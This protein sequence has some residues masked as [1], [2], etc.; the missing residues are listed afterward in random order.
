ME[1]K[2]GSEIIIRSESMGEMLSSPPSWIVRSGNALFLFIFLILLCLSWFIEYPDEITGDVLVT[3]TKAP[4]EL[5]NQT[6]IQLKSIDVIENEKVETGDLIAQFDIQANTED[7]KEIGV[8][9]K[10]L[11]EFRGDY[12]ILPR[13][14][15]SVRLGT[16]QESWT[17][18]NAQI[19]NWNTELEAD[20]SE[21]QIASIQREIYLREQLQ[22]IN[23]KRINISSDEYEMIKKELESSERLADQNAIS[24]QTLA[25]DKRSHSQAMQTIQS[26][27]EQKVQN[28]IALNSL[29]SDLIQLKNDTRLARQQKATDILLGITSLQT[30]LVNWEKSA[31]WIAPCKGKVVFNKILQVNR[32]YKANE[33]SV[34]IVPNGSGYNAIATIKVN[35]AGKVKSGQKVFIEL[36]DYPKTEFGML[37]GIVKS[38]TQIDKG[39]KYEVQIKLS[40]QL[41][42]TYNKQIPFKAQFKGK[43]KI[44]T[45]NKRL[46]A[47]FFEQLTNLIK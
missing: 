17:K 21:K 8:Y 28:L 33:A 26:Q 42:T 12:G 47:R 6:Y 38:K 41:K 4:I 14:T 34:V 37:E 25:T 45:K 18:L 31:V 44:I 32:F 10:H 19:L 15:G 5:S 36:T 9:L 3:T 27:K 29:K 13:Y 24:K 35:G 39:G 1:D 2:K 30:A 7:I 22:S 23:E 40:N 46:L 43:V 11:D 16:F 20:V